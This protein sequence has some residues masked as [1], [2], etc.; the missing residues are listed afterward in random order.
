ML[1]SR[2]LTKLLLPLLTFC[3]FIHPYSGITA[4]TTF[5]TTQPQVKPSLP[6]HQSYDLSSYHNILQLI[7]DITDGAIQDKSPEQL[8]QINRILAFLV[9]QGSLTGDPAAVQQDISELLSLHTTPYGYNYTRPGAILCGNWVKKQWKRT[10]KF[11][12]KHKTALIIGAAIV[13]A[14]IVIAGIT[15]GA[16]TAAG[17]TIASSA[18]EQKEPTKTPNVPSSSQKQID[19][20]KQTVANLADEEILE[21]IDP[22]FSLEDNARIL[23]EL[24]VYQSLDQITE[25][26]HQDIQKA[27]SGNYLSN[28]PDTTKSFQENLHQIRGEYALDRQYYEQAL[29]DFNKV[30]E[31]NPSNSDAYLSRASAYERIGDYPAAIT[32]YRHYLA[33]AKHTWDCTIDFSVGFTK[34]FAIGIK[35]AGVELGGFVADVVIHPIN[36]SADIWKSCTL[37]RELATSAEW[38]TIGGALSPDAH[39]LITS[40]D[41]LSMKERGEYAG[42]AFGKHGGDFF[43]PGATSKVVSAGLSEI[44]QLGKICKIVKNAERSLVLEGLIEE[45]AAVAA[46]GDI[47]LSKF[48]NPIKIKKFSI[49]NLNVRPHVLQEKHAW[50]KLVK[51]TGNIEEDF[52]QVIKLL[53]ESKIIQQKPKSKPVLYPKGS[54]PKIIRS[55]YQIEINGHQVQAVFSTNIETGESFLYNAWVV[56][57]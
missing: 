45:G 11:V 12:K 6:T 31:T 40:W 44:K 52:N 50:D 16:T 55:D 28:I 53:E 22:D 20:I 3:I 36:T 29:Y 10:T 47:A 56:T 21:P 18:P 32:D 48:T 25:Q 49:N 9:E 51:I 41:T 17:S 19:S 39:K 34:G 7:Q 54:N 23:G 4:A 13:V 33:T 8:E 15:Y 35:D 43:I 46:K 14:V 27:F 42:H 57:E 26:N 30:I 37:L 38:S 1:R 24:L 5:P 2:I